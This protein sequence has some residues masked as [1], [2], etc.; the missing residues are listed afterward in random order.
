M[1]KIRFILLSG[2]DNRSVIVRSDQIATV[3]EVS[4]GLTYVR[5]VML[6]NGQ[7]VV[8]TDS[9]DTIWGRLG[10]GRVEV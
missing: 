7:V 2:F 6:L 9:I 8:A 4:N 3:E 1:Q 10:Y 5:H